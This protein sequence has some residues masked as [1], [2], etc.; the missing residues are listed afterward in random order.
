MP[1]LSRIYWARLLLGLAVAGVCAA[2]SVGLLGI[3]IAVTIYLASYLFLRLRLGESPNIPGGPRKLVT[4]GIGTYFLVWL[5]AW[6]LL[7]TWLYA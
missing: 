3:T 1:I 7:N 6:T 2:F 4:E 5:T